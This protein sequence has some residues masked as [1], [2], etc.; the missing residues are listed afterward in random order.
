MTFDMGASYPITVKRIWVRCA[1]QRDIRKKEKKLLHVWFIIY[2]IRCNNVLVNKLMRMLRAR[3]V[4]REV[5]GT[6]SKLASTLAGVLAEALLGHAPTEAGERGFPEVF[7]ETTCFLRLNR[8]PPCPFSPDTFG[9]V[10]HTDSDFLTVLCQDR[11]GG[12]QIMKGGTW[13]AVKPIPGALIVNIG[14][15][16]Q[17]RTS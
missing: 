17:V 16:F 2:K 12:L 14:D 7:D 11:V 9:L 3:D 8:Y 15:L 1:R 5:P 10:P 4:T 6:M 13:V